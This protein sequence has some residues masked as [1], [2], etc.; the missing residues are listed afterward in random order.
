MQ[1]FAEKD[2]PLHK[3]SEVTAKLNWAPEDQDASETL[4]SR[5]RTTP[6][7]AFPMMKE[8]FILYT[9]AS[10]TALGAVL[11]QVQHGQERAICYAS[12][13]FSKAQTRFF[14]LNEKC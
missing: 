6:I 2:R 12:K 10:V 1:Q 8:P 5:P 14:G 3:A 7:L 4:K 11:S 13:V 9:N